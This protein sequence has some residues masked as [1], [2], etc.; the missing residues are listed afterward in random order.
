MG[1]GRAEMEGS[2][3]AKRG[4]I[5]YSLLDFD[6]QPDKPHFKA[7]WVLILLLGLNILLLC[8]Q[9]RRTGAESQEL[10]YQQTEAGSTEPHGDFVAAPIRQLPADSS[11]YGPVCRIKG[12]WLPDEPHCVPNMHGTTT[13]PVSHCQGHRFVPSSN[14]IN[15]RSP[16]ASRATSWAFVG[17]STT[18]R[19]F[20]AKKVLVNGSL[21][22]KL[23]DIKI[24]G[25]CTA[26][27]YYGMQRARSWN[28]PIRGK[29]G[30]TK[31]GLFHN[32]CTDCKHLNVDVTTCC[33]MTLQ[34]YFESTHV[35][36]FN[37]E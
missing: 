9:R 8:N 27:A 35:V 29:E 4:N 1:T 24:G 3:S 13:S 15:F 7:A 37:S 14:C 28:R 23:K 32:G 22:G 12:E 16:K 6:L 10:Y 19:L 18:D 30:P 11:N 33:R 2:P 5:I 34:L 31:Y 20:E 17:D 36:A 26:L 21:E 25:R